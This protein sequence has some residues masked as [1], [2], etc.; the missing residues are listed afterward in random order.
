MCTLFDAEFSE[1]VERITATYSFVKTDTGSVLPH[2]RSELEQVMSQVRPL[3]LSAAEVAALLAILAPAH[4][5]VIG[6]PPGRPGLRVRG[7]RDE[8]AAPQFA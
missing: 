3:D 7:V 4:L 6:G 8:H 1:L 2:L 5:R